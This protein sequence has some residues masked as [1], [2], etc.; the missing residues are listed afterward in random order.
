MSDHSSQQGD[1]SPDQT[2]TRAWL[3]PTMDVLLIIVGAGL[4]ALAVNVLL[5]PN[6][7]VAG[8]FLGLAVMGEIQLK[9][10]RGLDPA[11]HQCSPGLAAMA[12]PGGRGVGVAHHPGGGFPYRS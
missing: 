12:L 7:I 11:G 6:E 1:G 4:N 2:P 3:R 8:G 9:H 5:V 10:S